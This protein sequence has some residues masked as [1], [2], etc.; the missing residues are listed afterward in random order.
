MAHYAAQGVH[1]VLVTAT[2]GEEGEI[3]LPEVAHLAADRD[4]DLG[5]YRLG[6]LAAAVRE[7]GIAEHRYLGGPGRWRDS[8]MM[9]APTNDDLR[10]FWRADVDEAAAELVG[11]VRDVRPQVLITYDETG[12]YGHPDHIQAHRV[13]MRAADLAADPAY[14]PDLG[15]PWA[16]PKIYWTLIPRSLVQAGIDALRAAGD[17]VSF[18]GAGKAEDLP[19]AAP[20][21]LVTTMLDGTGQV[22][23][24][25]A[26]MAAHA[27]QISL[28]GP[29]FALSNNLGQQVWGVE[30]YRLVRGPMGA[31][32]DDGYET[33][34]F[35]GLE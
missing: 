9:G 12:G 24:K 22:E 1:V 35:A 30:F 10:C 28:D 26:A 5:S 16:T 20:D 31:R 2:L 23:R 7:L 27:T 29:F 8:G 13:S 25:M 15:A 3:L 34:L 14:R 17:D 11:V 32:N 33:D 18:F 4:D 6:E 21:E 19:F